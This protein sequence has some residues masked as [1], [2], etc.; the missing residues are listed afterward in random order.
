MSFGFSMFSSIEEPTTF[1]GM[2]KSFSMSCSDVLLRKS[3]SIAL[4]LVNLIS[5]SS[6]KYFLDLVFLS[7]SSEPEYIA[8]L[9]ASILSRIELKSEAILEAE[10]I[11]SSTGA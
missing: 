2:T 11:S 7:G 8:S 6:L 1:S 9:R 3:S 5:F 10:S 4:F